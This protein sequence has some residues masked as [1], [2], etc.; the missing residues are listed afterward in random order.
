[1]PISYNIY[2]N[3]GRGGPVDYATPIATTAGLSFDCG[4][5]SA[6]GDTTFA[7]RAVDLASGLEEA[8]TNARARIVLDASGNDVTNRPGP[9]LGLSARPGRGGSCRVAW[10]YVA[11][12]GTT[13]P[14]G[15]D[16]HVTPGSTPDLAADPAAT[17]PYATGTIGYEC[18]LSGLA[19]NAS[20]VV[21]VRAIGPTPSTVGDPGVIGFFLAAARLQDVESLAGTSSA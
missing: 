8:N 20:Y 17:V 15:F 3:D 11:A 1:M 10:G 13:P 21:A 2:K 19:D 14:V 6:P 18:T 9:V 4:L 5:L 7:V 16:V 12:A